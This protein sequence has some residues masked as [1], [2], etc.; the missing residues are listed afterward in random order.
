MGK[1]LSAGKRVL[2]GES[3]FMTVFGNGAGPPEGGVRRALSGQHRRARPAQH[4]GT[5]LCQK[6]SFLCAAKGISVGIA[7]QK[8]LGAG[9][10]GGEGFILQKL[11]GDGLAFVHAGGTILERTL[12]PA[13]RCASTPAA[14]SRSR[15]RCTT[16]S[17]W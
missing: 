13:R 3:L 6:D 10:F 1:L 15:P 14:W 2:T 9:L 17:R 5:M 8:K 16:T 7:F 11:E 12:Q 4:G